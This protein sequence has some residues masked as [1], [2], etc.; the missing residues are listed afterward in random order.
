MNT[1]V[2]AMT[3]FFLVTLCIGGLLVA[4]FLP[5]ISGQSRM[6]RR[7]D[8]ALGR[9]DLIALSG[10]GR[11]AEPGRTTRR[12]VEDT[13]RELESRNRVQKGGRPSA[14]VSG[15]LRQAGLNWTPRFYRSIGLVI[16]VAVALV[17]LGGLG[18]GAVGS[19][20]LGLVLGLWLPSTY[21]KMRIKRRRQ[22]FTSAFP[23]A[24][25]IIVRGV[26][27]GIPLAD[28]L[29]IVASET[30]DPVRSEFR[31]LVEDL[32]I[33]FAVDEAVQRMSDRVNLEESRFF[34]VVINI[35]TRTGG[36]LSEA[37]GNLSVVLRDRA[38]MRRKIKSMS[39]EATASAGI[40][41]SLPPIV[42]LLVF[43]T[44]P[45][46]VGLLFTTTAGNV[47]L[48]ISGLWMLCGIFIMRGM[49]NFDF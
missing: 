33:G 34:S 5:Q 35:Q 29:R 20:G 16:C 49:I 43:L 32:T 44:S 36:N 47:V 26:R 23:D 46:Y 41:G 8:L 30:Q 1:T 39:S 28:C 18:V 10:D 48:A 17:L 9:S 21:V 40:I 24:V 12:S 45:Q 15:R 27:A 19:I 14:N 11:A 31:V 2:I 13:L 6:Q 37:L 4:F 42:C 38:K 25:D 3:T 22:A 7:R